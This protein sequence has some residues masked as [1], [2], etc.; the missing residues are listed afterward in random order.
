MIAPYSTPATAQITHVYFGSAFIDGIGREKTLRFQR[1][2][3]LAL[4]VSRTDE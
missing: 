3:I 1:G 4:N 2:F